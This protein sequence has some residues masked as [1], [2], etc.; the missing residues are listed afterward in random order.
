MGGAVFSR[1]GHPDSALGSEKEKPAQTRGPGMSALWRRPSSTQTQGPGT[2]A[3]RGRPSS[4]Q[5][6]GPGTSALRGRPSSTQAQGPGTS[7]LGG[8][9]KWS[10]FLFVLPCH[11][12]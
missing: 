2:S 4:T 8:R 10:R 9:G 7:A 3:L 5:A 1:K 12:G 6:Q 11:S